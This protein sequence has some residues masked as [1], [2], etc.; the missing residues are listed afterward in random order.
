MNLGG[1]T[2]HVVQNNFYLGYHRR[3][4]RRHGAF[5]TTFGSFGVRILGTGT[6]GLSQLGSPLRYDPWRDQH[7]PDSRSVCIRHVANRNRI[8]GI[9]SFRTSLRGQS[10]R[11]TECC[12]LLPSGGTSTMNLTL[13]NNAYFVGSDALNRLAQVGFDIRRGEFQVGDFDPTSTTPATNLRAYTSTLSAPVQTT[14]R[15]SLRQPLRRLFLT[16][17]CMFLLLRRL[18]L[19]QVAQRSE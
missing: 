12:D 14:T 5:T 15:R 17:I 11:N 16:P 3:P 7:L 8:S 19:N 2:G 1:S 6:L 9:T 10:D 13:N 4:D 18:V